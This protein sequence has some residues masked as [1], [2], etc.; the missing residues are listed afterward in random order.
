M[1]SLRKKY[2]VGSPG[3]DDGPP[4]LPP[5]VTDAKVPD[6]VESKPIEQRETESPVD[7]A[8][9][10]AIK[11]RLAEMERAEQLT[12]QQQQ[13]SQYA[14]EPPQQPEIPDH[15]KKWIDAHPQYFNDDIARMELDVAIRK[16]IRDR[17]TWNDD[18]FIP[19]VERY[20]GIAPATNGQIERHKNI[21]HNENDIPPPRPSAPPR[22]PMRASPRQQQYSAPVSAPPTR[23]V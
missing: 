11:E 18:N 6:A 19:N 2:A 21:V 16:C 8:A 20:L 13:P 12:R 4:V 9:S 3:N 7:A 15:V 17:L 1:A 5:P 22:E 10:T 23:E 14:S